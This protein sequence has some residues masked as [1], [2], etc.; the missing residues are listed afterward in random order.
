MSVQ[1][2]K[3]SPLL[4]TGM[5]YEKDENRMS[6]QIVKSQPLARTGMR[7]EKNVERMSVQDV[8]TS[9][10]TV[11]TD[12]HDEK[13]E[14]R[15]SV[16]DVKSLP[17][18]RTEIREKKDCPG[19]TEK[20]EYRLKTKEDGNDEEVA[21]SYV[22]DEILDNPIAVNINL[23]DSWLI[24]SMVIRTRPYL[25]C[26]VQDDEKL[27]KIIREDYIKHP[28]RTSVCLLKI[29]IM[30]EML[31]RQETLMIFLITIFMVDSI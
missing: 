31:G 27:I 13:D 1:N 20:V 18:I 25:N 11:R 4:R 19:V 26:L 23:L 7:D 9:L 2:V 16:K 22:N 29:S 10:P 17:L 24:S 14:E 5:M 28:T 30:R 3:S 15:M 8:I 21:L 6:V 12:M